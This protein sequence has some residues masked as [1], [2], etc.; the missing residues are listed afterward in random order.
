MDKLSISRNEWCLSQGYIGQLFESLFSEY[1]V[2]DVDGV[3]LTVSKP[4]E[5]VPSEHKGSFM[6]PR[7][8]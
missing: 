3:T 6:P 7:A 8:S 2:S 4:P 5:Q 1:K